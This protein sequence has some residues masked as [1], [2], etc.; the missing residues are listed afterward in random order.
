MRALDLGGTRKTARNIKGQDAIEIMNDPKATHVGA[1]RT[2]KPSSA[3]INVDTDGNFVTPSSIMG[4]TD[5]YGNPL[6]KGQNVARFDLSGL[7]NRL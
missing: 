5:I 2:T 6:S 4:G 3:E 7:E 1:S